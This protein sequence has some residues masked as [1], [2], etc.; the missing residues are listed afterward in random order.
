[1]RSGELK[2]HVHHEYLEQLANTLDK[3]SNRISISL[4]TAA[5]I[6]G[7]SVLV[8]TSSTTKNLGTVGLLWQVFLEFT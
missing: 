1:M 8:T 6:V 3:S 5:L 4:I 7:S 2:I